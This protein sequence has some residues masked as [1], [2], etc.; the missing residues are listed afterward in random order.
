M[1]KDSG[2][3]QPPRL[4][5]KILL[6]WYS[7]SCAVSPRSPHWIKA[8]PGDHGMG[9]RWS[10][11]LSRLAHTGRYA[12]HCALSECSFL[13][14]PTTKS[15]GWCSS[16]PLKRTT[17]ERNWGLLPTGST[18]LHTNHA[19]APHWKRILNPHQAFRSAACCKS[20]YSVQYLALCSGALTS[21]LLDCRRKKNDNS[22]H[23]NSHLGWMNQNYTYFLSDWLK[24]EY[25]FG[26]P[27]NF[28][29]EFMCATSWRSLKIAAL[30]DGSYSWHQTAA[31][32]EFWNQ[33][34][35]SQLFAVLTHRKYEIIN[36]YYSSKLI[37]FK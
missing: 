16:S 2:G 37:S 31:S 5:P 10:M 35:S 23:S 18:H 13:G 14:K 4:P 28:S 9:C 1:T 27:Q 34:Q 3:S 8:G 30:A 6:F 21:F 36:V 25:I 17:W 7:C 11:W 19:S 32:W 26:M 20:V 33:N 12:H 24:I 15:W 22:Q 29:N